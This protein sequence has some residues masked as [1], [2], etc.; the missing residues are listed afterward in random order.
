[1]SHISEF[2]GLVNWKLPKLPILLHQNS[3]LASQ[4]IQAVPVLNL[5]SLDHPNPPL[6]G[7]SISNLQINFPTTDNFLFWS[8]KLGQ[9][10]MDGNSSV[11]MSQTLHI[12]F[13]SRWDTY[14]QS[15]RRDI[16]RNH[17]MLSWTTNQHSSTSWNIAATSSRPVS[18]PITS[19]CACAGGRR[20]AD[21]GALSSIEFRIMA[22]GSWTPA[23]SR[24]PRPAVW[25]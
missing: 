11:K 1:M 22:D 16:L 8:P 15:V 4:H 21:G 23:L 25:M 3:T 2:S 12:C 14:P 9:G 19:I 24:D 18:C 17:E 5:W 13:D 20:G 7:N 10:W 6:K